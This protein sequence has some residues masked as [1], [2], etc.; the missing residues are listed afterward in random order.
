MPALSPLDA[1]LFF[2]AELPSTM[3]AARWR[4][5]SGGVHGTLVLARQQTGGRGRYGN[6]WTSTEGG[7]YLS[8]LVRPTLETSADDWRSRTLPWLALQAT[9][10][11]H[12]VVAPLLASLGE[13]N[14]PPLGIKWPNDLYRGDKK[15]SGVLVE[16]GADP[17]QQPFAIIGLGLNVHQDPAQLP[18]TAT[19]LALAGVDSL[20]SLAALAR[21]W[22][23]Q[24][25]ALP[26]S[27]EGLT[28]AIHERLLGLGTPVTIGWRTEEQTTPEKQKTASGRLVGVGDQAQ[29]ILEDTGGNRITVSEGHLLNWSTWTTS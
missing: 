18:P 14:P 25:F 1:P 12:R 4:A 11:M 26:T 19:S 20:P 9:L 22:R 21:G 7:L 2:D 17:Q 15:L 29:A 3:D 23:E 8:M 16:A 13:Q 6:S 10:A 27:G 24:F 5:M 28:A